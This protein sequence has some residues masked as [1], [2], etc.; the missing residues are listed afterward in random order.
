MCFVT[1]VRSWYKTHLRFATVSERTR[2]LRSVGHCG[3]L[4]SRWW[5]CKM[6]AGSQ[7]D[8]WR[9]S[10]I[11]YSCSVDTTSGSSPKLHY[12]PVISAVPSARMWT[13]SSFTT[14]ENG[15]RAH[16]LVTSLAVY[17]SPTHS[18]ILFLKKTLWTL[19]N[20]DLEITIAHHGLTTQDALYSPRIPKL[21]KL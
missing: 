10:L 20:F 19:A 1:L 9:L 2:L 17:K 18:A 15:T 8:L 6:A 16:L 3:H 14:C 7:I 4:E 5:S 12:R 13:V 11:R 21:P